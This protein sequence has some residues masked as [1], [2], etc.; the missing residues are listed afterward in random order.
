MK[1]DKKRFPIL[2]SLENNILTNKFQDF[3]DIQTTERDAQLDI[4]KV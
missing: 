2:G 1:I 3:I 4:L